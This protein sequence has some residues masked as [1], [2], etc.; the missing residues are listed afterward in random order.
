M[1]EEN[2][3]QRKRRI[4][5]SCQPPVPMKEAPAIISRLA[6]GINN[7][8]IETSLERNFGPL[9]TDRER[10]IANCYQRTGIMNMM[11]QLPVVWSL[12]SNDPELRAWWARLYP[13][14]E[15]GQAAVADNIE[16]LSR[17]AYGEDHGKGTN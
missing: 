17:M 15:A 2:T 14:D 13:E 6:E 7:L 4:V 16:A 3:P 11:M 10:K 1:S 8:T 5:S 12:F 9:I